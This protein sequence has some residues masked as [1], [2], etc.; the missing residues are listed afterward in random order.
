LTSKIKNVIISS[1][2]NKNKKRGKRSM[3]KREFFNRVIEVVNASAVSDSEELVKQCNHELELLDK[4]SSNKK[5][6]KNQTENLDFAERV[7]QILKET[8]KE[9]SI[10]DLQDAEPALP[11]TTQRMTAILATL[12]PFTVDKKYIKKKAYFFLVNNE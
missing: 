7:V 8:G 2:T 3:T 11:R 9:M 4:K 12:M 6:T 10:S 5:P 1:E